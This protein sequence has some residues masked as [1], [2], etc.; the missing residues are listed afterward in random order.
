VFKLKITLLSFAAALVLF[1][2]FAHAQE[3]YRGKTIRIVIGTAVGGAY[4]VYGQLVSRHMGKYLPG[5]PGVAIAAMPGAGGLVA[6][7][8]LAS[9]SP[10]KDGTTITLA[11]V[12]LVQE[13]LFNKNAVFDARDFKWIGRLDSLA[14]I[15]V[16]SQKSGIKTLD[17]AK[18]REVITGAPGLSNIP[19]QA[20]L[21]LNKI[22]DTKFK[23][24]SGY[25]G[26][27]Q[28]FL[29]LE[30]GE[31]EVA[32]TSVAAIRSLHAGA[33]KRGEFVPIF[34]HAGR[35][36]ADFPN[37][38]T[39]SEFADSDVEKKFMRVFSLTSDIGR[40]LAVPPGTPDN[41]VNTFRTAY[42]SM[43][44]DADFQA[45]A[46]KLDLDL[47]AMEGEELGRLVA[48]AMNISKSEVEDMRRF[49]DE[50]F[51]SIK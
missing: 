26:T 10:P 17:D 33:M 28:V 43:M 19:A 49:Y 3:G 15:G 25:S 7:N 39:L 45:D 51:G 8:Y 20:P 37:V 4:G 38:P 29:A 34:A 23:L 11:H 42:R 30:R 13:S 48:E 1:G 14:F 40:A 36:L 46:K 22:A 41:V 12:T 21:V 47:D 24:I 5:T 50:L 27:G 44:K 32:A 35:R 16:A 2:P 18:K 9:A 6:L 31:V